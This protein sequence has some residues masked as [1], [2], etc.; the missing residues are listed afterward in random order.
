[1]GVI[2]DL[3]A[4]DPEVREAQF[5]MDRRLANKLYEAGLER[6]RTKREARRR[7]EDES[8]AAEAQAQ[9]EDAQAAYDAL[10]EQVQGKL[11]TFRFRPVEP[12][13]Y[14]Q[15]KAKHRPTESQR[16]EARK[17]NQDPPEWNLETFPPAFVALA[18]Y[19]VETPSGT[20]DGLSVED[21]EKIWKSPVWNSAERAELHNTALGAYLTRT[22]LDLPP[23]AE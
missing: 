5:C 19:E 3:F 11:I 14:D 9:A 10:V 18:C 13:D 16:T 15:L 8:A 20:K 23:K 7:Y 12:H 2:D 22:R 6:D 17:Q 1:M 21:A 4:K